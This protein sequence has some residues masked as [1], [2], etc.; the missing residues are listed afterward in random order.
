MIAQGNGNG[1]RTQTSERPVGELFQELAQDMRSLVSLEL[2]LAKTE[3]TQKVADTG[4][5]AGF[6]AA[7]GFVA[8]AGFLAIVAAIAFG[9]ANF[10]PT[11]L[12]FLIVGI[13]VALI[14]YA[15]IRKGMNGIKH[16]TMAPE[17]TVQTLKEDQQWL[18]GQRH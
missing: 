18:Q 16:R 3:L 9:L 8:Y 1:F 11:W 17:Q 13:V 10:I 7:G 14:G 15:I 5:D 2:E 6:I 4:K 12:S